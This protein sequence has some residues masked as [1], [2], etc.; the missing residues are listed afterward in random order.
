[1]STRTNSAHD[2]DDQGDL[3][4]SYSRSEEEGESVWLVSYA[5]MMTLI[6][7]LF[8]LLLASSKIDSKKFEVIKKETTQLFGGQ[9]AVPYKS[10]SED[11]KVVVSGS[12]L[13]D[14]VKFEQTADGVA[15]TFQGTIFFESGISDLKVSASELLT[16]LIPVIQARAQGSNILIEGHT[17]DQPIS[18]EKFASN[19]ELS[20]VRAC[21]VLRLF[22]AAGFDPSH[23]RA[24]GLSDTKPIA[25]ETSRA[26]NRRVVIRITKGQY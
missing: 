3:F 2:I 18:T 10:L 26:Q 15:I 8:A 21:A 19:W 5:D 25:D 9:Y 7:G 13:Q 14:Q 12:G 16:K 24:I 6:M 22:A 17:D 11:L 1:M 23:L 20:S 4:D